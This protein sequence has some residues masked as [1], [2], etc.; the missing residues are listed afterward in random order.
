[1]ILILNK[2]RAIPLL[3][4]VFLL[5]VLAVPR[6]Q[7]QTGGY[8]FVADTW[9]LDRR[10]KSPI[11][12][13]HVYS[14]VSLPDVGR[15][16]RSLRGIRDV[17]ERAFV[18]RAQL[19]NIM[20]VWNRPLSR[21]PYPEVASTPNVWSP[22]NRYITFGLWD[23]RCTGANWKGFGILDVNTGQSRMLPDVLSSPDVML[24]S[25]DG[26]TLAY[27]EEDS[28]DP[29]TQQYKL[30]VSTISANGDQPPRVVYTYTSLSPIGYSPDIRWLPDGK[31]IALIL[32]P[33]DTG[34]EIR[35]VDT[36]TA[37]MT[38]YYASLSLPFMDIC[39]SPKTNHFIVAFE[40]AFQLV[41][42]DGTPPLD[43]R[44]VDPAIWKL[45]SGALTP[46]SWSPDGEKI[47]L[48]VHPDAVK[49]IDFA[50]RQVTDLPN[51]DD[52]FVYTYWSPD[53]RMLALKTYNFNAPGDLLIYDM[54][55]MQQ[56]F[57]QPYLNFVT[58]LPTIPW[59]DAPPQ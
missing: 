8:A 22:D 21:I 20:R 17:L 44:F 6:P 13:K 31:H 2:R 49:I 54:S 39:W 4:A 5:L 3:V 10:S 41:T 52:S 38:F 43:T 37:Q 1:M 46:C 32:S 25:P 45:E 34:I 23:C 59:I 42:P 58:W 51:I 56:V 33:N 26:S 14:L 40:T 36:Q 19:G 30:V 50:A 47:S 16:D 27:M 9:D 24:W 11:E 55:T 15:I 29:V 12:L 48:M 28:Y 57:Y 35:F 18:R 53:S 7:P